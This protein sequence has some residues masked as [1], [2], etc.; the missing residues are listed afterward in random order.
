MPTIGPNCPVRRNENSKVYIIIYTE[1]IS[2]F[3]H[4]QSSVRYLIGGISYKNQAAHIFI[5]AFNTD[6]WWHSLFICRSA[7]HHSRDY[8]NHWS[9][10]SCTVGEVI[11]Q[12]TTHHTPTTNGAHP[13][14]SLIDTPDTFSPPSAALSI[15]HGSQKGGCPTS[16]HHH[17]H[18]SR[19]FTGYIQALQFNTLFF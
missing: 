8:Q 18:P 6:L 4:N 12:C 14:S 3:S 19:S 9:F 13:Q 1:L 10:A 16:Q 11:I 5:I 2:Q 17:H 15:V 7:C